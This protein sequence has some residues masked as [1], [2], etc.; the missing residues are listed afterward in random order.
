MVVRDDLGL[1]EPPL[2]I[3]PGVLGPK[4]RTGVLPAP[5]FQTVFSCDHSGNVL[6][7][8]SFEYIIYYILI[9]VM[10]TEGHNG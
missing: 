5:V 2:G 9:I 6:R 7:V 8:I 10:P 3:R 1:E 4:G